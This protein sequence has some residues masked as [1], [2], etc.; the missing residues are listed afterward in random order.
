MR[1]A[2]P[3]ALKKVLLS[4]PLKIAAGLV[5]VYFLFGYFAVDPLAKRILPWVAENKLASRASVEHVKFDPLRLILTVDHLQLTRPDGAPLAA[6]DRLY[7]NLESRGLLRFAWQ[8]KDILLTAPQVTLD[9]SP[10]GKLNWADL[11]AKL[12]EDK[13]EKSDTLPRVLIDHILITQGN[14]QYSERNRPT[15]FKA[16][17]EPLGLEL[18]GLSTL[19]EDRGDYQIAAKLPEQGGTLKWKGNIGLNPIVSN[20]TLA[21]EGIKLTRLM[22]VAPNGAL[23]FKLTDGELQT[24]LNYRFAMVK[25][26]ESPTPEA[27]IKDI[28]LS[29]NHVQ[30]ELA[31]VA[32]SKLGLQQ[33]SLHLPALSFSMQHGIKLDM[34]D[35]E[36]ALK[37][38]SVELGNTPLFK[39]AQAQ[40]K[41]IDFNLNDHSLKVAHVLLE[42]GALQAS[43][44][45]DG[46]LD[47][48]K[49]V[50]THQNTAT[51]NPVKEEPTKDTKSTEKPFNINIA[52]VQ[53]SH[54]QAAFQD[55]TF[56]QPLGLNIRNID[57][58][59]AVS[60]DDGAF[61]VK[62]FESQLRQM[63]LASALAPQPAA[64]LAG[65]N[66]HGGEISL[67]NQSIKM[68]GITLSGLQSQVIRDADHVLNWQTILTPA[69]TATEVS[70]A[71]RKSAAPASDWKLA[72]EHIALDNSAVHVEDRSTPTPVSLDIQNAKVELKNASL[73]LTKT[74]PVNAHFNVKQGGQ[75]DASGNLAPAPLKGDFKLKLEAL[76]FKPFAPYI[77]QLAL[78]KLDDG[79]A[80]IGGTL[81]VKSDQ[82]LHAQFQGGF[83]VDNLAISEEAT[84]APFLGWK[85]LGSDSLKLSLGPDQLHIDELRIVQPQCKVIIHEDKTINIQR[86]MRPQST[87]A[88]QATAVASQPGSTDAKNDFPISVEHIRIENGD[89]EFADLSLKPQ[90]GTHMNTLSGVI[91]G[92]STKPDTT[93]Q[94]ELDGKVDEYGSARIRGA[95]Q[96]FRATDFT[97]LQLAFHNLEM[98]RLTPYSGK[99][100]GRRID[101][102]R[103]SVDL[104][105]KI[106]QR[107]LSGTNK[108]VIN[109]LKLGERVDSPDA[110]NLPLDLAIAIL[111][112]SDG[113]IDLDLPVSGSLDDPQFSYGKIVWKAIVNVIGKIATAPFRALGNLLGISSEKLEAVAF[114][115][116]SAELAPPEQEKL[117]KLAEAMAKRPSLVLT[118]APTYDPVADK[119]ALQEST[120]RRDLAQEAGLKLKSGEK[121]GPVDVRNAKVQSAILKL[122][123]ERSPEAKNKKLLD[124]FKDYL[125]LD[126]PTDPAA[127]E[128]MLQQL[129]GWIQIPDGD[130]KSLADAR[131]NALQQ[132]LEQSANMGDNR[133]SKSA[134]EPTNGDGH[135]IKLKMNLGTAKS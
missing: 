94:V 10:E 121:P 75:F 69:G 125:D 134:P 105:Y 93:A 14:I 132:K 20:G 15:P 92:L 34:P 135:E 41:G 66:L 38:A 111:E 23:P 36:L 110:V 18:D 70:P 74:I 27:T 45:A 97:D 54:W 1:R 77:N 51:E 42:N 85:T 129:Q 102:G 64:T 67:K 61:A 62:G 87:S 32:G 133:I 80:N 120:I 71:T 37:Q 52:S 22:Q 128:T 98:N 107:Q 8:I 109:K 76:S 33:L 81:T 12:N 103:M 73:N 90:F 39:L 119:K 104:E 17:L 13:D 7:V 123:R 25:G 117:K 21:L 53:L 9:I 108:F 86:I 79:S 68:Q 100:A 6:F 99:F 124:K 28:A 26:T 57:V 112:D 122:F 65:I 44:Q 55:H 2:I 59:F 19:P 47:W 24:S 106:K 83:S 43:R 16:A 89:F 131:A 4:L 48:Q 82:A 118:V 72:L 31:E 116:G 114:D 113:N 127:Y 115:P 96:P 40:V 5:G 63:T 84:G 46:N 101:S 56:K 50:V 78:L 11:I 126:K 60:N 95:I 88:P 35:M 91:N 58:E 130:L 49:L 30:G 3:A 29:L